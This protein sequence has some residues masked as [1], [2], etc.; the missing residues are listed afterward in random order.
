MWNPNKALVI[1]TRP[2]IEFEN[3]KEVIPTIK[4]L[5]R[6]RRT[7][8]VGWAVFLLCDIIILLQA[9]HDWESDI[10]YIVLLIIYC[11]IILIGLC[12][13]MISRSKF[14]WILHIIVLV[15][16]F[17]FG[18]LILLFGFPLQV[19]LG[20]LIQ[21]GVTAVYTLKVSEMNKMNGSTQSDAS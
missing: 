5:K 20:I 12:V 18:F 2:F 1:A 16:V 15:E 10:A 11:L 19:V 14:H 7:T 9:L 6:W 13:V 4:N 17:I 8:I 21:F 3:N